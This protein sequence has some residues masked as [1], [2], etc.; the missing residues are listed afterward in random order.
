MCLVFAFSQNQQRLSVRPDLLPMQRNR[1]TVGPFDAIASFSPDSTFPFKQTCCRVLEVFQA[2][3][4]Q[5]RRLSLLQ[6]SSTNKST[7]DGQQ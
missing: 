5:R 6:G 2:L 4:D 3:A 1:D 7:I